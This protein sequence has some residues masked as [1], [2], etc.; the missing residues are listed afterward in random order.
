MLIQDTNAT[1]NIS[2]L[3]S[4][5]WGFDSYF[6][7]EA[8]KETSRPEAAEIVNSP[9]SSWKEFSYLQI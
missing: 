9:Y 8:K 2:V 1:F 4:V 5:F 3:L 6:P 7:S